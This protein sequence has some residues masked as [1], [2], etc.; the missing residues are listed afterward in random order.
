MPGI[1]GGAA[2][3]VFR[4]PEP[5]IGATPASLVDGPMKT[6]PTLPNAEGVPH[7]ARRA[8]SSRAAAHRRHLERDPGF[9]FHGGAYTDLD[10][11]VARGQEMEA[12][13]A[14]VIDVGG[15][16]TRPGAASVD[17]ETEIARVIPVVTALAKVVRTPISIDVSAAVFERALG[18]G[19]AILNDVTALRADPRLGSVAAK[20][21]A[22]V[23]LMHMQGD[24]QTMQTAPA[25]G[26]VVRRDHRV[27]R[28]GRRP[29]PNRRRRRRRDRA[30]SGRRLRQDGSTQSG[31]SVSAR[32]NFMLWDGR[33]FGAFRE[34]AFSGRFLNVLIRRGEN[35][36]VSPWPRFSTRR[37][38][39]FSGCMTSPRRAMRCVSW[40]RSRRRRQRD[41]DELPGFPNSDRDRPPGGL[42]LRVHSPLAGHARRRLDGRLHRRGDRRPAST[43]SPSSASIC[44]TFIG[45]RR[46]RFPRSPSHCSS[47]SNRSCAS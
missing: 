42:E 15:V 23:V 43:R 3:T 22:G 10:R 17:E 38:P 44:R 7:R 6:T 20:G 46:A 36:P 12:E 26:D 13:G 5:P 31:K 29:G 28:R 21:R 40:T 24:P 2:S 4:A 19:A 25:Y 16:S 33:S 1:A 9:L 32:P 27:P 39:I 34:R 37:T 45:S 35:T 41:R 11:A 14:D 30:R 18:A 47:S 8:R